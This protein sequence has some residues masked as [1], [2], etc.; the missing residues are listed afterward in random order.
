MVSLK[1]VFSVQVIRGWENCRNYTL[2]YFA[3]CMMP[4]WSFSEHNIGLPTTTPDI[5]IS[6][7]RRYIPFSA[8]T[9]LINVLIS[10]RLLQ[11]ASYSHSER[12]LDDASE[13]SKYVGHAELSLK[14]QNMNIKH[15]YLNVHHYIVAHRNANDFKDWVHSMQ[16]STFQQPCYLLSW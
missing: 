11:L 1:T 3:T 15:R 16:N 5:I 13:N 7:S 10:I 4:L 6:K 9:R 2:H 14:L 8:L 12:C